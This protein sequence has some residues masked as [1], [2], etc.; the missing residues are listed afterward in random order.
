MQWSNTTI[1]AGF[2]A[3]LAVALLMLVLHVTSER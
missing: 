2:L 3:L 1:L